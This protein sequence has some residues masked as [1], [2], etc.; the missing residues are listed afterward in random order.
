M[1]HN[2]KTLITGLA[3]FLIFLGINGCAQRAEGSDDINPVTIAETTPT[4][5][6]A[7]NEDRA[8]S[9]TAWPTKP[10]EG[11]ILLS[12]TFTFEDPYDC[13]T[14][15]DFMISPD[16]SMSTRRGMSIEGDA[17]DTNRFVVEISKET[18]EV[19]SA[20]LSYAGWVASST[21]ESGNLEHKLHGSFGRIS[22]KSYALSVSGSHERISPGFGQTEP[23][24]LGIVGAVIMGKGDILKA[25]NGAVFKGRLY[26]GVDSI[27][28]KEPSKRNCDSYIT[29]GTATFR[30]IR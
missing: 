6:M 7:I 14:G 24:Q 5:K 9:S 11:C 27:P 4:A 3:G 10:R 8:A 17:E 1:I 12:G 30:V 28:S 19:L 22:D 2:R 18:G 16:A 29:F 21:E 13:K 23:E 26:I 25:P 20:R 15:R